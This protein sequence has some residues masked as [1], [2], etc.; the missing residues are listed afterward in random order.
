MPSFLM[1]RLEAPLLSFGS[2]AIDANGPTRDFPGVSMMTG[3]LANA[4][5]YSRHER[6]KHQRL[7]D[8]LIF[9]V[10]IDRAG[11]QLLDFQTA[12]LSKSD[13]G[14]TTRGKPEGRAGGED[15]YD[16]PH[17]RLRHYCADPALTVAVRLAPPDESPTLDDLTIAVSRPARPLFIGRKHCLPSTHLLIGVRDG[18]NSVAALQA[19][20]AADDSLD[21]C[22]FVVQQCELVTLDCSQVIRLTHRRDWIAGVHTGEATVSTLTLSAQVPNGAEA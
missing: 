20:P 10:R 9:G 22:R 3:L 6:A 1:L 16:S 11:H 13:E 21:R 17:I 18:K 4:L 7:Q 15:T 12:R 5:G 14:W 8:R 19:T 2:E